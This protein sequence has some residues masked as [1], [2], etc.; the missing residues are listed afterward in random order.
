MLDLI[1]L[2]FYFATFLKKVAPHPSKKVLVELFKKVAGR[3]GRALRYGV[4]LLV[5]AGAHPV[6]D[7]ATAIN[8]KNKEY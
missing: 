5:G 1:N 6:G 3:R 2:R 4:S 7:E 8:G